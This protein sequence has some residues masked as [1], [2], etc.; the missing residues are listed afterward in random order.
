MGNA[1]TFVSDADF[2]KFIKVQVDGK[3][4]DSKYY[5]AEAGSTKITLKKEFIDTLSVGEHILSIAST[6]GT[7]T[8]TFTVK[9]KSVV[10]ETSAPTP[11]PTSNPPTLDS[12]PQPE[13][14][15]GM[16]AK[17]GESASFA[18]LLAALGFSI[19][20]LE[21]LRK[22]KMLEE[23]NKQALS[24]LSNEHWLLEDGSSYML[25]PFFVCQI[26]SAI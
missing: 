12:K 1:A 18:G 22:K 2:A 15:I 7:A 6:D 4:V 14:R 25:E 19:V 17:T 16:I 8:T 21:I 3:D 9:V 26:L 10:S 5:T 20:G 13:K 23:N 24:V 11:N